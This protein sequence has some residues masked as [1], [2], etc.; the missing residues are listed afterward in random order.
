MHQ[1]A[2]DR[3]LAEMERLQPAM[4]VPQNRVRFEQLR[5]QVDVELFLVREDKNYR[6]IA[7]IIVAAALLPALLAAVF[8]GIFAVSR[9]RSSEVS[10]SADQ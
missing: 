2:L 1:N 7:I 10:K 5:R 9:F 4:H 3:D 8:L 6:L